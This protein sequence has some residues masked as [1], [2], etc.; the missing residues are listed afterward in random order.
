[1]KGYSTEMKKPVAGNQRNQKRLAICLALTAGY[2]DGYGLL[3]LGTFVSF[4]SGNTTMAGVRTGQ[5]NLLAALSPAIAIVFF[6]LGSLVGSVITSSRLRRA[7][8]ILFGIILVLLIFVRQ[9]GSHGAAKNVSIA[10]LGLGMG[11]V[12]P[13]LSHIGAE[14]VSL[15]FMTGTLSRIGSHL[16]LA[17]RRAPLPA[18]EGPWDSHLYRARIDAQ[19]WA[20]FVIGAALSGLVTSFATSFVLVPAIAIMLLLALIPVASPS[21]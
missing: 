13:A 8:R 10:L 2:L 19:L 17:L 20:A 3:V 6:V 18:S 12:N 14:A 15:T 21:R 16:A 5:A 9:L 7:H 11:M 1:M 4:M